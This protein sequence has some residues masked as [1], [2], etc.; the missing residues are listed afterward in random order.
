[1]ANSKNS[2][3]SRL[4]E[5]PHFS[6]HEREEVVTEALRG[7]IARALPAMEGNIIPWLMLNEG[8]LSLTKLV[9]RVLGIHAKL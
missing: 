2:D 7:Q 4:T 1:M 6:R 9:C 3:E 5:V 8:A